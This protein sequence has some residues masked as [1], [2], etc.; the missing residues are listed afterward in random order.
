MAKILLRISALLQKRWCINLQTERDIHD[1]K[2]QRK[3][4]EIS[5]PYHY[6]IA[7]SKLYLLPF[8]LTSQ[9]KDEDMDIN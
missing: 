3:A 4:Y 2:E 9:I 8:E 6:G 7:F 1:A 5:T